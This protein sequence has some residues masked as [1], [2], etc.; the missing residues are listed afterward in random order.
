MQDEGKGRA[1]KPG[2]GDIDTTKPS[3][4]RAYDVV[5]GGKDNYKVDRAVADQLRQTMPHID[6]LA[7]L[8]REA[9][10]RTVRYLTAEAGID[11]LIDLGA[12]L[13]TM[14]N[15]HQ[16]AQRH[17][18]GARVVYVDNDPIVL[19]HGR[20]LLQEN[21]DTFV[22]T[23]DLRRPQ[24]ILEHPD[25]R[26]LI[27]FSRPVAILLVGILHHLHDDEDPQ[28]IV[29][30]YM[31]A[32]PSGSHLVITA[33]CDV[34]EEAR[35]LQD[36]FLSFLGTGR[37]RTAAEIESY[38]TGLELLEP[39]VV[40]LPHWRPDKPVRTDLKLYERLMAGGVGRKP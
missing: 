28:G 25:V 20:A 29:D 27:D 35:A 36:T 17:L 13:P 34:G 26:R 23:A 32:V 9:L 14:E 33:F 3:I 2:P 6:D 40:S 15:T 38:F 18:P 22:I 31:D 5:L 12:G 8:N 30:A 16:V 1:A 4:A 7:W 37:F 24:E 19:A 39:G 11:Q 21:D 10:G